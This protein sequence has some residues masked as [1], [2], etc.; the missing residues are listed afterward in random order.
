VEISN[1]SDIIRQDRVGQFKRAEDGNKPYAHVD[2]QKVKSKYD[3]KERSVYV[4]DEKAVNMKDKSGAFYPKMFDSDAGMKFDM[5]KLGKISK[6]DKLSEQYDKTGKTK[7]IYKQGES[8]D[9]LI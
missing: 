2:N 9:K 1:K 5:N 6:E 8:I 4:S 7:N 3:Q